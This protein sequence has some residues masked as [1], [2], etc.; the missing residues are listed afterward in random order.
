[1]KFGAQAT[2]GIKQAQLKAVVLRADGTVKEDLGVVA[3][4]SN[5]IFKQAAWNIK[6]F[7]KGLFK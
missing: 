3:F 7:F 5:N 4:Y 1:M 2:G 6:Q